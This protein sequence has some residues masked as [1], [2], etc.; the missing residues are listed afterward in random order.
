MKVDDTSIVCNTY[1]D[2]LFAGTSK[3]VSIPSIYVF[4]DGEKTISLPVLTNRNHRLLT[5]IP[6]R[7]TYIG[8]HIFEPSCVYRISNALD[9]CTSNSTRQAIFDHLHKLT[10][11]SNQLV[12]Y[13]YISKDF[14]NGIG[15]TF[16]FPSAD[17][18]FSK[19]RNIVMTDVIARGLDYSF[20]LLA[21]KY[22]E[23]LGNINPDYRILTLKE[24]RHNIPSNALKKSSSGEV[25]N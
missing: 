16:E 21:E 4:S 24:I 18:V 8:K 14:T 23:I 5:F 15:N 2:E 17:C 12:K 3:I 19:D 20:E 22:T 13:D 1:E 10:Y 25:R 11:S 9:K 6:L 7:K